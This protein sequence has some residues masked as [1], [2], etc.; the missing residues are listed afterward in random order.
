MYPLFVTFSLSQATNARPFLT[1]LP[2]DVN[3]EVLCPSGF[4]A[5]IIISLPWIKKITS[6]I[7]SVQR[8]AGQMFLVTPVDVSWQ[9]LGTRCTPCIN[10]STFSAVVLSLTS[11]SLHTAVN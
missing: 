4:S 3:C 1:Q 11:V 10:D 9:L 5:R 7:K 8:D 6:H 2:R